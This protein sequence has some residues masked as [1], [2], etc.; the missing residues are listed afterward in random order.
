MTGNLSLISSITWSEARIHI[1]PVVSI[2]FISVSLLDAWFIAGSRIAFSFT[3]SWVAF[4]LEWFPSPPWSLTILTFLEK[5]DCLLCRYPLLCFSL[6]FLSWFQSGYALFQKYYINDA[7]LFQAFHI[8]RHIMSVWFISDGSNF[9]H[10]VKMAPARFL[11]CKIV[12]CIEFM[13]RYFET[14]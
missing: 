5:T 12:L 4:S 3:I 2:F 10:L 11:P 7:V 13:E 8:T 14:M 6:I 1:S 9:D